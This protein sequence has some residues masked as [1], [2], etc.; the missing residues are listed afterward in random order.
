[1]RIKTIV[2]VA[3]SAFLVAT[4]IGVAEL[5]FRTRAMRAE[6]ESMVSRRADLGEYKNKFGRPIK[7]NLTRNDWPYWLEE[8]AR[9]GLV[10]VEQKVDVFKFPYEGLPLFQLFVICRENTDEVLVSLVR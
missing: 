9:R 8:G 2:F 3:F 4:A 7:I 6:A 1:M 10:S 5:M